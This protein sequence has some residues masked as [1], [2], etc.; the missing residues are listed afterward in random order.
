[1]Q[2]LTAV[3]VTETLGRIK[4]KIHGTFDLPSTNLHFCLISDLPKDHH[5]DGARASFGDSVAPSWIEPQII[6]MFLKI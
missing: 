1:M 2:D 3:K 6:F 5:D 4:S